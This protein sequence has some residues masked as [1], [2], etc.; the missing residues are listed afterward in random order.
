MTFSAYVDESEP[1]SGDTYVLSC[2]LVAADDAEEVRAVM[3]GAK[4]SS[5]KKVHWHDRLPSE[6]PRLVELVA[7]LS[8]MH[9]LV[10]RDDCH[11][12]PS[13]R[14]RRK[15]MEHLFWLLDDRYAVKNVVMEARQS[16]QN[17]GD[18][19]LLQSMRAS[20]RLASRL[21][22]DHVPGPKEALLWVPDVVAGA[23]NAGR[24]GKEHL[25]APLAPLV[26][27]EYT[28]A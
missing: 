21:R 17:A 28:P 3:T 25:F 27:V 13:E 5:E 1:K 4:V 26:D 10:V 7:G 19:Q 16:K 18:L 15:C 23:F 2:A 20:K 24:D 14:R 12:E 9:L 6:H 8:S 22:L 11:D